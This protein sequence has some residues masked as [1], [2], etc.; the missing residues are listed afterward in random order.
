VSTEFGLRRL[1]R[2]VDPVE[3][4]V[5]LVAMARE[6]EQSQQLTVRLQLAVEDLED[7]LEGRETLRSWMPIIAVLL[8]GIFVAVVVFAFQPPRMS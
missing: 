2:R 3:T 7:R 5:A 4:Y 6:L 1:P 8:L